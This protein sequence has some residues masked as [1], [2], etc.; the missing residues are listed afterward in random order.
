MWSYICKTYY[1][2]I[3]QIE[4]LLQHQKPKCG[5]VSILPYKPVVHM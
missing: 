2:G 4:F 1:N 3:V 5:T